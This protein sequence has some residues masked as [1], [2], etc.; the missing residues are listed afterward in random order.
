MTKHIVVAP[1]DPRWP[2]LFVEERGRLGD[3]FAGTTASVEHV[4]ST[5]VPGLAAKPVIDILVGLPSL[6]AAEARIS[7]LESC[8]Y[9]YVPEYEREIPERRY[10]RRPLVRPRTHH[11]HCVV[12]GSEFW[13]RHL[14][15]RDHLRSHPDDA[16]EYGALKAEL[17][18]KHRTDGVAYTQGK[19][20]FI[21]TILRAALLAV[22]ALVAAFPRTASAQGE[23]TVVGI[24]IGQATTTQ[25]WKPPTV[26]TEKYDGLLVGAFVDAATPRSGLS[27]RAEG[28]YTERGGDAVLEVEG[29][30]A[31][32]QLRMGYLTIAVHLKLSRS[33][34]PVRAHVALGPT[35]DQ[36]LS[37]RLDPI[38]GQV[39]EEETPTVFSVAVGGGLGVWVTE[40]LFVEIDLRLTEGV[41]DAH[42]GDF[43][44]VRNRSVEG[45]LRVGIPLS[46]L[47]GT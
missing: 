38:L 46:V 10:Y 43:I 35:I 16:R 36:V 34:G 1:Y 33:L 31:S 4:G 18:A 26:P 5:S 19:S 11:L 47:R 8:G 6:A 29:R 17:A 7:A 27:V 9:H 40:R 45:L 30:P 20:A 3:V 42:D 21:E 44:T 14:A 37:R 12:E 13:R 28:A 23:G 39:F 15:F 22:C 41:S 24:V 25:L 2:D 32:T